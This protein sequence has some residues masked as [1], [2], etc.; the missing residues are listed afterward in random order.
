MV[1]AFTELMDRNPYAFAWELLKNI[2]GIGIIYYLGGWFGA[3]DYFPWINA[4]LIAWFI[5]SSAVCGWFVFVDFKK[6]S[7]P[8]ATNPA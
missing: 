8:A 7:R 4:V 5:I 3:G 6:E 2:A 1:Y